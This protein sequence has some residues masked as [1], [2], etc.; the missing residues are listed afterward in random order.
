MK[1]VVADSNLIPHRA[2]FDAAVPTG[3]QLSW[4]GSFD[5]AA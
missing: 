4:H 1:I 5:E 2:R 3:S